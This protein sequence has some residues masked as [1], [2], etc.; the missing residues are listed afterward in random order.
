MFAIDEKCFS[1]DKCVI[2]NDY[3]SVK[4]RNPVFSQSE[5]F[6]ISSS[7]EYVTFSALPSVSVST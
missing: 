1:Y 2:M 6:F 5:N 3:L 7:Y 4:F